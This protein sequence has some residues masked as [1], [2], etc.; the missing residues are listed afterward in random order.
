MQGCFVVGR[1]EV[2]RVRRCWHSVQMGGRRWQYYLAI[3]EEGDE[4]REE[5]I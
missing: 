5:D 3:E 2:V 1:G 4:S